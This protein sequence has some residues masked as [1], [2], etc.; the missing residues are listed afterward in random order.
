MSHSLIGL[1]IISYGV[2]KVKVKEN[3]ALFPGTCDVK[4]KTRG[5][6]ILGKD[7]R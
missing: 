6:R 5:Q 3:V 4:R 1:Q 7:E 2:Y